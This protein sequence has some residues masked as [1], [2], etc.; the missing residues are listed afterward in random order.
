MTKQRATILKVIR[1]D[2]RHY[3][4]EE[5]FVEV[6]KF[7]PSISRATV[8]N[9]LHALERERMIRRITGEGT[10]DRYDSSYIPHGHYFCRLCGDVKDFEIPD[11]DKMLNT[12]LDG[13]FESYELKVRCVCPRCKDIQKKSTIN[14][15]TKNKNINQGEKT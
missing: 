12:L 6:K 11:F 4:A 13:D 7:L 3:T 2:K 8:Y 1:S 15:K 10:S 9:N 14:S 5:L